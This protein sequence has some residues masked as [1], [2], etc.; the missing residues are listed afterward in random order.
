MYRLAKK[1]KKKKK[2]KITLLGLWNLVALF[3]ATVLLC[4]VVLHFSGIH[5]SG[6]LSANFLCI[7]S[8][9]E[10]MGDGLSSAKS[11]HPSQCWN[12]KHLWGMPH[13]QIPSLLDCVLKTELSLTLLHQSVLHL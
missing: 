7:A 4:H 6:A 10:Q 13:T 8:F 3:L 11:V 2:K 5:S 1:K 9:Y 12:L